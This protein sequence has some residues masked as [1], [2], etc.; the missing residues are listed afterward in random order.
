MVLRADT[1]ATTTASDLSAL[2]FDSGWIDRLFG[3]INRLPVP[4]WVFYPVLLAIVSLAIVASRRLELGAPAEVWNL[5]YVFVAVYPVYFLAAIH[6]L[7][8]TAAKAF[9]FFRPALGMTDA[10]AARL[11]YELTS[12]PRRQSWIAALVGFI[13]FLVIFAYPSGPRMAL[14]SSISYW[15]VLAVAGA[16]FVVCAELLY[17]TFRQL[18]L[19]SRIHASARNVRLFHFAPL[20]SFSALTARTGVVFVL[21]LAYDLAVNPETLAN[22][23]LAILNAVILLLCAACFVWPRWPLTLTHWSHRN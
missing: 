1:L 17:R 22:L 13:I 2:P 12:L 11:R 9:D 8:R 15:T 3:Q 18:R 19:V 16:G 20:Y 23:P 5:P 4:A 21:L 10:E 14:G 7:D 6:Y